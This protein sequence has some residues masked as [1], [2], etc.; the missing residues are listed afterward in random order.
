MTEKVTM[1]ERDTPAIQMTTDTHLV[2][3]ITVLCEKYTQLLKR[4]V[5]KVEE[6]IDR[7]PEDAMSSIVALQCKTDL[8][9]YRLNISNCLRA[10]RMLSC[11]LIMGNK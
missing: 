2:V 9:F 4:A 6:I 1:P 3:L 8:S 5:I 7:E 11:I 10:H